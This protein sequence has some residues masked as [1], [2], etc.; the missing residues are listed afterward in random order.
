MIADLQV[1]ESEFAIKTA[2]EFPLGGRLRHFL[3]FW[4]KLTR[5][6]EILHIIMGVSIP[7]TALPTQM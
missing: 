4:R 7:F 6:P 1:S 2:D 5:D 3:N